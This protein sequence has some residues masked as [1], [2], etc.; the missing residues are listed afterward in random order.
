MKIYPAH[1][2]AQ[3]FAAITAAEEGNNGYAQMPK[4]RA[5]VKTAVELAGY[6]VCTNPHGMYGASTSMV[7]TAA[8]WEIFKA[9]ANAIAANIR[10]SI[11]KSAE[12]DYEA[13]I[14]SRNA[15]HLFA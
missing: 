10:A 13:A 9:E 4:L 3:I 7:F 15:N 1:I 11:D 14:L 2:T 6:T 8:A 5:D 12:F